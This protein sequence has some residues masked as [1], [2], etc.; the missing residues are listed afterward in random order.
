MSSSSLYNKKNIFLENDDFNSKR[1]IYLSSNKKNIIPIKIKRLHISSHSQTIDTKNQ[2]SQ[3]LKDEDKIRTNKLFNLEIIDKNNENFSKSRN[4]NNLMSNYTSFSNSI[5]LNKIKIYDTFSLKHKKYYNNPNYIKLNSLFKLPSLP[6]RNI[7]NN[8]LKTINISRNIK[9]LNE[10]KSINNKNK[11]IN[12]HKT[13]KIKL[14]KIKNKSTIKNDKEKDTKNNKYN[15]L[16]NFMKYKYYEDVNEK[17][18]KKLRDD[19]FINRGIKDKIIR[20]GKVG[21]FWKNVFD[22]CNPI[23][24]EE[25]CKIIKKQKRSFNKDEYIDKI[26]NK[27][28]INQKLYTNLL[29]SQLIHYKNKYNI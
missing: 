1:E 11:S 2:T 17:L 28:K 10:I 21:V 8:S 26:I 27:K 7:T 6:K 24:Y 4:I 22:Y 18:E 12:I 3:L 16:S 19:L 14:N 25:K 29:C 15:N 23:I 9:Y 20:L 5:N 13:S